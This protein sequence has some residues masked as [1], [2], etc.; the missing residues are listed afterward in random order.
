VA[1]IVAAADNGPGGFAGGGTIGIAP[2]ATLIGVKVLDGGSGHFSWIIA[3]IMYAAQPL[4]EGGAGAHVINMSLGA[5]IDMTPKD[6]T[7]EEIKQLKADVREL[8]KAIS[9]AADYAWE[10]GVTVIGAAGNDATHLGKQFVHFPSMSQKVISVAATGPMGWALGANNFSRQ[11]SYTNFGKKGVDLAAPG[12]DA[13]L[14]GEDACRVASP[15]IPGFGV[16]TA[17]WVFDMYLSTSRAGLSWAAGT[18]MASPV[19]AGV[20]ALII[21]K[22]N[23]L[24]TPAGVKAKLEQGAIDLGKPGNDN[25]YGKGWVNAWNSVR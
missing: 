25:V 14:P 17:C 6:A 18:S 20:A 19:A 16:T 13:A 12:G 4:A 23:G 10:R 21:G 1:G 22:Y 15:T 7:K 2:S 3:G 24:I 11:A 8:D 9:R 5:L